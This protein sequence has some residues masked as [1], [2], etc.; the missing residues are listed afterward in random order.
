M[1]LFTVAKIKTTRMSFDRLT[2]KL[3]YQLN[4]LIYPLHGILH[5]KREKRLLQK[6]VGST[7]N[8]AEWKKS[9]RK[10]DTGWLHYLT[11]LKLED[12]KKRPQVSGCQGL[13]RR[14]GLEGRGYDYKRAKLGTFVGTETLCTLNMFQCPEIGNIMYLKH[15]SVLWGRKHYVP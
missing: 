4:K 1:D 5:I 9:I 15:V 8:H 6:L 13:K 3:I 12:N 14:W 11:F 10:S 7:E 2:V